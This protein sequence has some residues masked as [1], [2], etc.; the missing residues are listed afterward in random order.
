MDVKDP[1]PRKAVSE[2]DYGRISTGAGS[3]GMPDPDKSRHDI[4]LRKVFVKFHL[5]VVVSAGLGPF[6][7]I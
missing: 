5:C 2:R 3:D 7:M 4:F 6:E 1:R